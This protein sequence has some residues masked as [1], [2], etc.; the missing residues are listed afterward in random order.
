MAV[1]ARNGASWRGIAPPW[2]WH[3]AR[4]LNK[5]GGERDSF[6]DERCGHRAVKPAIEYAMKMR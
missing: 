2:H 4:V 3:A 1:L 5:S 6:C